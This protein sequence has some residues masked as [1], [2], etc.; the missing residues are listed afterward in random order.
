VAAFPRPGV[1]LYRGGCSTL[2][3]GELNE[4]STAQRYRSRMLSGPLWQRLIAY[5]DGGVIARLVVGRCSAL[6]GCL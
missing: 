6:V 4:K 2:I 1:L 3:R 5:A